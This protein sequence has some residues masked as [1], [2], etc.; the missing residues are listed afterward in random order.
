MEAALKALAEP[1]RAAILQLVADEELP[2]GDIADHF[3]VSRP[4]ISQHLHILKDAGLVDE[5]RDGTKRLY[6]ARR[7]AIQEIRTYLDNFWGHNLSRLKQVA[8]KE[9]KPKKKAQKGN[10]RV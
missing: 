6:K 9:Q 10:R 7:E 5:R 4:A 1:R 3:N 8:E 2:A